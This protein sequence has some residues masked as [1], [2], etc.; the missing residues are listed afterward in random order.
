[1]LF[2]TA[3]LQPF[4]EIRA[5]LRKNVSPSLV[6]REIARENDID[7]IVDVG[8]VHLAVAVHVKG[9]IGNANAMIGHI[10]S[11]NINKYLNQ[12]III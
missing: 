12:L 6:V 9:F 10:D 5:T 1:M 3:K 11:D 2:N 8:N 4:L 7:D